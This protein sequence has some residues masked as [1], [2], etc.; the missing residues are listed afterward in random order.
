[1]SNTNE[2]KTRFM[3]RLRTIKSYGEAVGLL[4]WDLRTGAP[5]KGV[6]Q[7]SKTVGLLH[8]EAHKLTVSDEMGEMLEALAQPDVFAG[9]SEIEQRAVET[10]KLQY[11]RSRKIPTDQFQAYVTLTAEAESVWEEAKRNADFKAFQPYLEKIVDYNRKF[12][13]LWGYEDHPYN[14][15][16]ED[17][18]PGLTVRQ[19]D[20][21]F[22]QVKKQLVPLVAQVK[23]SGIKP[24]TSFLNQPFDKE[25]QLA[26]NRYIVQELGYDFNAGRI[27]ETE[28]PFAIGLNPGD[29]R[30]TTRFKPDELTF[31]LFSTIHECGHALYEQNIAEEIAGTTLAQGAS[32]GIHESQ[33][34]F[35]EIFIGMSRPFW[36]RYLPELQKHF[37]GQ[38][39]DVTVDQFYRAINKSEPSLIRI[40]ADELTYN[41]H[42]MIRYEIEKQLIAG[43]I[44][45]K[46]LPEIWNAKY[47]EY[48]GL[49][50]QHDGEGVLQDVHWSGGSFGYFPSYSLGNMYAAQITAA[51][52]R[53]LPN[54][55]ELVEQGEFAPI[56]D[57][58]TERIYRHGAVMKPERFIVQ[59]TGEELN[60][61]YLLDHLKTKFG[62]LYELE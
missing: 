21:W 56:K 16:L 40:E 18:E 13:E 2:I 42:I 11:D 17:Y 43:Q 33:S 39:D 41:L 30:I 36:N 57:W 1:M 10:M 9:L 19:L 62:E 12:A 53:D 35:W 44:E 25:K 15:L 20:E 29:V 24:D 28:H 48:L 14:A 3:E 37:P 6:A 4:L 58:L 46:D 7:R 31:A 34:R 60:V 47:E 5:K 38:L 32:Y 26:F 8:T 49:R 45:V 50:P 54:L 23:D 61:Q 51:I 22:G 27:D 55:D 52:R 59:V